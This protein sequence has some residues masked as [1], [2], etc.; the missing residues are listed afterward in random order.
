MED[1]KQKMFKTF[2]NSGNHHIGEPTSSFFSLGD[3][4]G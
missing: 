1:N 2:Y 3:I 4:H